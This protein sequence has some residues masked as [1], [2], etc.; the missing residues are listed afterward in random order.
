MQKPLVYSKNHMA[1][2][3]G[4]ASLMEENGRRERARD[5]FIVVP[6]IGHMGLLG[7]IRPLLLPWM[8][9]NGSEGFKQGIVLPNLAF[10]VPLPILGP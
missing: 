5:E 6:E 9:Q 4:A 1:A 2:R 3:E 7:S 10:W 8:R